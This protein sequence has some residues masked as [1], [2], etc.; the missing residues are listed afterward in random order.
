[1][2]NRTILSFPLLAGLFTIGCI[3]E[4]ANR[5]AY[6]GCFAG[7]V[8]GGLTTCSAVRI[9]GVPGNLCTND[10][11]PSNINNC[12]LDAVCLGTGS[13]IFGGQCFRLCTA[14]SCGTLSGTT[15]KSVPLAGGLETRACMPSSTF[16]GGTTTPV[17][18]L[19]A[20]N[21]CDASNATMRCAAGLTCQQASTTDPG[22][23]LGFTCTRS[24]TTN[25]DCPSS[26]MA[27]CVNGLCALGCT[28]PTTD[29]RCI[30]VGTTCR[31]VPTMVGGAAATVNFCAP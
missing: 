21:K 6:D 17:T 5:S 24:C 19:A 31:V 8:C 13:G 12:G 11:D 2:R 26:A 18:T 16:G 4:V 22:R 28:T 7:D 23:Q 20:Y 29:A 27:I 14:L 3:L 25:A 1:M 30:Q 15:C 9:P 10:C